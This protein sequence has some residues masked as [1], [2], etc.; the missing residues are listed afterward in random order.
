MRTF[1]RAQRTASRQKLPDL[2]QQCK[3]PIMRLPTHD[4]RLA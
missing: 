1:R 3:A 2:Q 4:Q